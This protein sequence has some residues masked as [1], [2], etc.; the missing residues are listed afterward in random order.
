MTNSVVL[1]VLLMNLYSG[2]VTPCSLINS[3]C[4]SSMFML[5]Q[6]QKSTGGAP[7]RR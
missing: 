5:K 3:D 6:S 7:N 2:C 4:I 1:T